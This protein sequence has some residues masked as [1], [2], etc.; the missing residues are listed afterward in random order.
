VY[1]KGYKFPTQ[2]WDERGEFSNLPSKCADPGEK[3]AVGININ[4]KSEED[5]E[6]VDYKL[7]LTRVKDG[8]PIAKDIKG[9]KIYL[10][11]PKS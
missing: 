11:K 2:P 7:E 5:L 8:K 1:V 10:Y 4:S 3:V 6:G 9:P